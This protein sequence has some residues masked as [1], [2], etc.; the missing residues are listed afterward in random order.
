MSSCRTELQGAV[1]HQHM[2]LGRCTTN[3]GWMG[4]AAWRKAGEG[5]G[6]GGRTDDSAHC[7]SVLVEGVHCHTATLFCSVMQQQDA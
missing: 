1:E 5:W 6:G 4:K 3:A 2:S 7:G